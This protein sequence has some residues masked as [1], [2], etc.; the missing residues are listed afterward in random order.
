M[1]RAGPTAPH[2]ASG[3]AADSHAVVHC[4][5]LPV[6]GPAVDLDVV[7]QVLSSGTA[8][9]PII[10]QRPGAFPLSRRA[11]EG[12]RGGGPPPWSRPATAPASARQRWWS[13]SDGPMPPTCRWCGA[14]GSWWFSER[15]SV[16]SS[17]SYQRLWPAPHLGPCRGSAL[18]VAARIA[19][20]LAL[21]RHQPVP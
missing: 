19:T 16:F 4:R 8:A 20:G 13:Q 3:P 18:D 10:P 5:F 7:V 15:E 21:P 2:R 11:G 12:A 14:E 1:G 9:A 17:A 6:P